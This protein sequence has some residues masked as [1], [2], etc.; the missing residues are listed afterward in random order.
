ML[1][2]ASLSE[3]HWPSRGSHEFRTVNIELFA[4][5]SRETHKAMFLCRLKTLVNSSHGWKK[6]HRMQQNINGIALETAINSRLWTFAA[7][8]V[9]NLT[10][11]KVVWEN[12]KKNSRWI[13]LVEHDSSIFAAQIN[14]KVSKRLVFRVFYALV[15]LAPSPFKI[16]LIKSTQ[17]SFLL[18]FLWFM[19]KNVSWNYLNWYARILFFVWKLF[20]AAVN[21]CNW[22]NSCCIVHWARAAEAIASSSMQPELESPP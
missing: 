15:G 9:T 2:L 5:S 20:L 6:W 13:F 4:V 22:W 21:C 17:N 14:Q 11:G 19:L 3:C 1:W 12:N 10:K 7:A 8:L 18:Y 16:T